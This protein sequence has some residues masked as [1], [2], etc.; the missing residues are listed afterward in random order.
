TKTFESL[1]P[2][3]PEISGTAEFPPS[4]LFG[5]LIEKF[6]TYGYASRVPLIHKPTFIKQLKDKHNQPSLFLLNSILAVS[7]HFTDDPRVRSDPDKP[8]TAGEIFFKRALALMD[9]FMDR[10]RLS[11][12]QSRNTSRIWM[13]IGMAVRMSL[14]L[15]LNR[16]CSKLNISKVEKA[17]RTRVF[18]CVM[19]S[20]VI[21]CAS[22]GKP[23][24]IYDYNT[25]FPYEIEEDGE[26]SQ[27]VINFI[28]LTKL[29]KIYGNIIQSKPYSLQPG[30]L[31][32]TLPAIE[33]SLSSWEFALPPHLRYTPPNFGDPSPTNV[34]LYTAYIHQLYNAAIISLHRPY[35]DSEELSIDSI[36]S[37]E[38]CRNAAINITKLSDCIEIENRGIFYMYS[39]T[40]YCLSQAAT[41]HL[42]D[43]SDSEYFSIGK[44][45]MERCIN[46]LKYLA[47]KSKFGQ[48]R[49]MVEDA[50]KTLE[51]IFKIQV[52]KAE[53][54]MNK[55]DKSLRIK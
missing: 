6:L 27:D 10:S 8:E 25:K 45:Y 11:T 53:E 33:A 13:F 30:S 54:E 37:R 28:H 52:A 23:I 35:I 12:V 16:D 19:N 26:E 31:R 29:Y 18:W 17:V 22:F 50:L 39:A 36:D 7:S 47:E 38:K 40:A 21:A 46:A 2:P 43:I 1:E 14:D 20:E 5:H 15:S 42:M 49:S 41:I 55:S 4:D 44:M 34:S 51:T 24:P 9:D 48:S 32:N 3:L